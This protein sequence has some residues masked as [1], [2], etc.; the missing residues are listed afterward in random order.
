MDF[1]PIN[2][3]INF[4]CAILAVLGFWAVGRVCRQKIF[5]L[6]ENL[7]V[8]L[9]DFAI[10]AWLSWTIIFFAGVFGL[11]R[12]S[13]SLLILGSSTL[14]S[15]TQIPKVFTNIKKNITYLLKQ[16]SLYE[17][18]LSIICLLVILSAAI[19]ALTPPAAQD[20]L[21]HHLAL[22]KDYI[23][24]GKI[25]D[26]PYNYFSY[27]PAAMEMLFLYAL[28]IGGAGMA[29]L[30]HH[31]FGVAT[32]LAILAG[33]KH[34]GISS[35]ARLLAATAFLT[36]PT[37]WMEM[38]W[39]YI[40]LTLTFYITLAMLALLK[41]RK[42]KEFSWSCLFG[43]ALGAALSIKYTTLFVGV[44][45]PLLI[46]FVLK[47]HKETSLK[48]VLKYLFVPGIIA[49]LVSL[50]WFIRNVA[51]TN[52]PLFPF[53][54][55]IFPSNNIGW[56]I[57]RAKNTLVMLNRYGGDKS[58]LDYL[59]LPFK[60]SFLARYESDQYYQGIIGTFYI[61]TLLIF[62]VIKKVKNE[63]LYL[64]GFSVFFYCF[65][66]ASSQQIR[67]L[68]PIFPLLSLAIAMSYDQFLN[69][70]SV[71]SASKEHFLD[72]IFL[73][74]VII[75]F[76]V[77]LTVIGYYFNSFKYGQ[78]FIGQLSTSDYLRNKF[79]YYIAY[80]HINQKTPLD[81]KIFLVDISNQ[82]FYL[83]RD[84]FGDSVFEDYTLTKIVQSSKTPAEIKD[85]IR[86]IGITH[87]L[88][89]RSIL[90][91]AKTMPFNKEEANL[92]VKFLLEHG[93]MLILND[94]IALFYI[95]P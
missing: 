48:A 39:A 1:L 51:W 12:P 4:I 78:L 15:A 44:I 59:L 55:N 60:L 95:K 76:L 9:F 66:A 10:G 13:L 3:V 24:L 70:D 92:F 64:L 18:I 14:I 33:G 87:L 75:I 34:L 23:K 54:L 63:V 22:P 91:G 20:A 85:K 49:L 2:Y 37:V 90:L 65:W 68:L 26:L 29:T 47:E 62:F 42:T 41:W 67:Y 57:D 27:F 72:K 77:N 93:E 40:D 30:L 73:T 36:I 61:L 52:N 32:F 94:K 25:I 38:T 88:Y 69:K 56:D 8:A 82:P 89:R 79:D 6:P 7:L 53:L 16:L 45:I 50:L 31:F 5:S 71:T 83:E 28:L 46:L 43:F 11:Y 21:V 81:S 35:R 84:Y 80:E 17:V 19:G 58:F 74:L 86:A